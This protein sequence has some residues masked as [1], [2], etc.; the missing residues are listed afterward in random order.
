MPRR[1]QSVVDFTESA[2]ERIARLEALP[3]PSLIKTR[4]PVVLLHGFGIMAAVRRRGHLHSEAMQLRE[5]G[6]WAY[7]PN[8]APYNT[9]QAR[10]E[11][12]KERIDH[13]LEETGADQITLIAHSMGGLDGRYLI[14]QMGLHDRVGALVTIS[15]PHRGSAIADFIIEQP[16]QLQEWLANVAD[17][18]GTRAIGEES[19]NARRAVR[20]LTPE[21]M[22]TTFNPSVP[23]HPDVEYWSYAGRAGKGTDVPIDPFF[24]MLN[25][26]LYKREGVNDGYVSVRSAK[27]GSFLGTID[28]DHARQVGIDS[29]LGGSFDSGGFYR[30]IVERLAEHGF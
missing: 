16:D 23:D 10:C 12:W 20:E 24:Y 1:S 3:Q 19:S 22:S 9:V 18:I 21:F 13:V 25:N 7:A 28:A 5:R 27:W 11:M 26:Y 30:S 29:R 8:V 6:V 14:S 15:T 17:W 2:I 4:Y